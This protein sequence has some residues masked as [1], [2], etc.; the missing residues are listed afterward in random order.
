[1]P[2]RLLAKQALAILRAE[3]SRDRR[4]GGVVRHTEAP[5]FGVTGFDESTA[6]SCRAT[7]RASSGGTAFPT[8]RYRE[9]AAP[10]AMRPG[11]EPRRKSVVILKWSGND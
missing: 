4:S 7:A 9:W 2:D 5:G 6:W 10:P 8:W 3:R 1:M 11:M